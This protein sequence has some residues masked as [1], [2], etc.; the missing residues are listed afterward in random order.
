MNAPQQ[1]SAQMDLTRCGELI[2]EQRVH[3]IGVAVSPTVNGYGLDVPLRIESAG[4]ENR[5]P[6]TAVR[7]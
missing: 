7:P 6:G 5:T 2:V 1:L 4:K 3:G